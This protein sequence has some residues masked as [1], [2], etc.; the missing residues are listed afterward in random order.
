MVKRK[1]QRDPE[2]LPDA[3]DGKQKRQDDD[4]ESDEVC[5]QPA[6]PPP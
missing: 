2:D 4:S 6:H 3:P 1:S 5:R